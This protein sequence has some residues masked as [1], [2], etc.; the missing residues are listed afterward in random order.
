MTQ[1]SA[2]S[3]RIKK[4]SKIPSKKKL[5]KFFDKKK[6]DFFL[7]FFPKDVVFTLLRGPKTIRKKYQVVFEKFANLC[8]KNRKKTNPPFSRNI[9]KKRKFQ[10]F[11]ANIPKNVQKHIFK[12]SETIKKNYV[13]VFKIWVKK[14]S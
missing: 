2:K 8:S 13:V 7:I 12:E 6:I 11:S 4:S 1:F 9:L 5:A 3:E 10:F 14:K